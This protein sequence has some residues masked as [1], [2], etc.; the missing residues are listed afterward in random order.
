VTLSR[1]LQLFIIRPALLLGIMNP[2][3]FARSQ[4]DNTQ[5]SEVVFTVAQE[6]QQKYDVD[7][8][9]PIDPVLLNRETPFPGSY[10]RY[11]LMNLP[12]LDNSAAAYKAENFMHSTGVQ[13]TL[14]KR[15]MAACSSTSLVV[16]AFV[17]SDSS[18]QYFRMPSGHIQPGVPLDC[19]TH[20]NDN[21][22]WGFY[23]SC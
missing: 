9:Q 1:G 12:W 14:A 3:S 22:L 21:I 18:I 7:V 19:G 6:M 17:A 5:C 20:E 10:A 15:I 4:G 16:F 23:S 13:L 2:L 8:R 11:F